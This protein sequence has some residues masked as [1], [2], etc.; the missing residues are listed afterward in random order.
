MRIA[1][2]KKK[3]NRKVF[4]LV[5]STLL[6][7]VVSILVLVMSFVRNE[8]MTSDRIII[9]VVLS[10]TGVLFAFMLRHFINVRKH[11]DCAVSFE[12]GELNDYTK[13]FNK[14][15]GLKVETITSV[16]RWRKTKKV[17]QYKITTMDDKSKNVY[18]TDYLV[19]STE[20][21]KLAEEIALE[22]AKQ[23]ATLN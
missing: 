20:L 1:I 8:A 3:Y 5:I 4:L 12:N 21:R 16:S 2:D 13:Q 10:I 18:L 9:A 17:N 11:K 15:R 19:D 23:N 7:F 6:Q 14:I 22:V